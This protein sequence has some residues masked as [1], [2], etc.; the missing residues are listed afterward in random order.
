MLF[1]RNVW[2]SSLYCTISFIYC[3]DYA[4]HMSFYPRDAMLA[5]VFSTATCLS[6][7][8]SHAGTVLQESH[9]VAG[10]PRDAAVNSDRYQQ[11]VGQ[12]QSE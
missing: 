10:K 1:V 11:P 5:R 3:Q 2:I 8:L 6:V 9:A 7:R 12:K 4:Q